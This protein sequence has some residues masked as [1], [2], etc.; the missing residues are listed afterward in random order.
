MKSQFCVNSSLDIPEIVLIRI[1]FVHVVNLRAEIPSSRSL[2]ER[3]RRR[4][5][6]KI[7]KF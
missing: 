3:R 5:K 4:K 7:K 1:S 2:G 6:K